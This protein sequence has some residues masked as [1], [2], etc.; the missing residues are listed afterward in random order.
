MI[1]GGAPPPSLVLVGERRWKVRIGRWGVGDG[2]IISSRSV[3]VAP[4]PSNQASQVG[5]D[6]FPGGGG[7]LL[8][9]QIFEKAVEQPIIGGRA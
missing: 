5:C 1:G 3:V 8:W 2:H 9:A 6:A 7:K 4:P